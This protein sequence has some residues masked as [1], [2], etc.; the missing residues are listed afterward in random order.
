MGCFEPQRKIWSGESGQAYNLPNLIRESSDF[1]A[2]LDGLAKFD[3]KRVEQEGYSHTI[4]RLP[5]RTEASGLSD[6]TY[7]T[8]RLTELLDALREEAKYLLLFLKSV[9]KIEVVH[10][11]QAGQHKTS[12]CVEIA[13]SDYANVSFKRGLLLKDL[14]LAHKR[15]P[16]QIN[17]VISFTAEF[18]VVVTDNNSRKNQAGTSRWLVTNYVGSADPKIQ[19]AAEKQCTFPWVGAALELG[20]NSLGGRI[21]CFLPMPI[22]T[23]SG[24]PIHVNGTFGLNDERRTLKWPGV[25]RKND[26]TADWNKILVSQLLPPC[27]AMLLIEAKKYIPLDQ[28]YQAW[29]NV[30]IVKGTQFSEILY[31]FFNNLFKNPVVWRDEM[32]TLQQDGGWILVS[33]ATFVKQGTNLPSVV[34]EVLSLCKVQLVTVPPLI[35]QAI[36]Y[37]K[38]AVTEVSPK[39]ARSKLR[40]YPKSYSSCDQV[41]K[42]EILMYCLSDKCFDD[43]G[44]LKLL[45]LADGTFTTFD[46]EET[47]YL[48]SHDCP[49]SLLP[50]LDHLLVDMLDNKNVQDSLY[51]VATSQKTKLRVL[52]E[53]K[54]A[55]LL[56]Q[57]MPPKYRSSSEHMMSITRS[58]LPSSWLSAFWNWLST[59]NLKNFHNRL[60]VPCYS[61]NSHS[62]A[63]KFYLTRL[64]KEQPVIYVTS[65]ASD[66][67]SKSLLSAFYKMN[68]RVCPQSDFSFVQ[69]KQLSGYV[70]QFD[71]KSVIDLVFHSNDED[72]DFKATEADSL[73]TFLSSAASSLSKNNKT[74]LRNL[75]IFKSAS[76]SDGQLFSISLAASQSIVSIKQALGE[77]LNSIISISNLP[78]KVILLSREDYHQQQLLE[79]LQVLFPSDYQL[80]DK[81]LL[82]LIRI[83]N[84]PEDLIDSFMTEVLDMFQVFNSRESDCNLSESLKTLPFVRTLNGRKSPSELFNPHSTSITA[85]YC[86]EDVFP[87]APYNTRPII[88]V[89]KSCGLRTVVTPQEVLNI[90]QS[91]SSETPVSSHAQ[92][93]D[94]T[95]LSRSRAV[96]EYISTP[97]FYKQ[98]GEHYTLRGIKGKHSFPDA[99]KQLATR[100]CWLPVLSDPPSDY[101]EELPWKGTDCSSHFVSLSNSV[102]ILSTSTSLT[103]PHLVGSQ[104]YLVSPAVHPKVVAKLADSASIVPH[105]VAHFREILACKER[106]SVEVMNSLVH[107]VYQFLNSE[108][109]ASLSHLYSIKEWIYIKKENKF[110]APATVALKQNPE[111]RRDLEPYIYILP[112]SL[113]QYT[114]LFG[115]ESKVVRTITQQQIISIL[116][117]IRDDVQAGIH[118]ITPQE[119]WRT[120]MSI[121]NWLTNDGT[122]SVSNDVDAAN[123]LIP[124]ETE[125]QWPQLVPAPEVVYTD[126][127]FLKD[128]IQSSDEKDSYKFVHMHISAKLA[129]C[130]GGASLGDLLDISEDTFEDAGQSEP[131]TTRLKNILRDY[132]DGLTIFKEL[133]QNADDA[134]AT[135]VNVCFDARQHERN[136][137]KL[138]FSGMTEAHGPALVVHNNNTFSDDDFKNITMLAAATKQDKALKIGKFGIGFCSVYHMTDIPSF[139]SRDYLHFFDPTLSYLKKLIKNP[140][141]PG[142]KVKFTHRFISGSKQL[143]P[144]DGLF[145][146]DRAKSYNGTMFRLPFRTND[147]ELSGKCYTEATVQELISAIRVNG[148]KL[149][150]FLQHVRTITFQ[151][152]DPGQTTPVVLLKI[153]QD[154]VS[155]PI[156]LSSGTEI[157]QL[158][159]D[160]SDQ[161]RKSYNWLVSEASET[162]SQQ[163]YYTA[164]VACPLGSS[165][166]KVDAK[167]EGEIFC[168]LPLS[169][170]TGLPVHVSSNFAV[171]NNRR[172]IWTSDEA[173]SQTDR[174][175]AWN[176]TLME[177][178]IVK[179]YHNLL[180]ALK[181]LSKSKLVSDYKFYTLWPKE[182]N[183]LQ[184]NPWTLMGKKLYQVISSDPLFYSE[185]LNQWLHLFKSK[186]LTPGI[187]CQA[188]EQ[189]STL[190][191]V[192]NVLHYLNI[193]VVDLPTT[194]CIYFNL[195][196]VTITES[197]FA[198]LFFKN[199][200]ILESILSTRSEV[201]QYMLEVY[202]TEYDDETKR[203]YMLDE[204]FKKC[205]SIPCTPDGK[206]LRKCIDVIDSKATFASLFDPSEGRFPLKQL[207]DRHLSYTALGDLGMISRYIPHDM[208][209]E[210]ARTVSGLYKTDKTKALKRVQLIL[211]SC[212]KIERSDSQRVRKGKNAPV[213]YKSTN[214]VDLS[215]IPFLPVLP[216]PPDYH[217]PLWKGGDNELMC[218][219]DLVDEGSC[220]IHLAGSQ[221]AIV[222]QKAINE[223]GCGCINHETINLLKI[224]WS[225]SVKEVVAH[226]GEVHR[227]FESRPTTEELASSTDR[228]CWQ[229]YTFLNEKLE[230]EIAKKEIDH[231]TLQSLQRIACVWTG[232]QF[233]KVEVIA[234]MWNSDGP[235]LYRLPPYLYSQENLMRILKIREQFSFEDL[236]NALNKMKN[237]FRD[238][239][240]DKNCQN[241][242]GDAISLLKKIELNDSETHT[243]MLPDEN[244]VLHQSDELTYNDVHWAPKDLTHTYVHDDVPPKLAKKL[245]V[246][247]ARSK[248]IANFISPHSKFKSYKF[249][250]REKLT[251]RIQNILR[252]YPFDI[253]I[254]K[255]LLQ[256]A[257]DAKATKMYFILDKRTHGDEGL[258]SENWKKLQGPA[259]LVWNDSVFTEKD[260][261]GIQELGLGSKRFDFETIGQFGIGFN[262]VYHVTDCPSFITGGDT[263][264]VLDPHC[265][266]VNEA[267]EL[268]PG[269]RFDVSE[270]FWKSFPDMSSSYLQ[271][272]LDDCPPEIKDGSLFRFPLRTTE[273]HLKMSQI[274]QRD[275]E[276]S[277]TSGHLTATAMLEKL[278]DWA[279]RMKKAML[280]L[281]HVTEL[282]FIVI[283]ENSNRLDIKKKFCTQADESA[284]QS[285]TKLL[286]AVSAFTNKQG[287]KSE[288]VRYSLT[289]SD[290]G[291][292]GS[293][294]ERW[295][296]QQGVG[297]IDN[298]EQVWTYV[299]TVKPRHGIA[300]P[301]PSLQ[302]PN[303]SDRVAGKVE[304]F[305][306]KE[307]FVGSVF[308]FLPLPVTSDLPVHINGN[309]DLDSSRRNLY[310]STEKGRED[311]RSTWNIRL[312]Q[313]IASSYANFLDHARSYYVS[314]EPYKNWASVNSDMDRYYD[315]FPQGGLD[316]PYKALAKN[317]YKKLV[318]KN[319]RVLTVVSESDDKSCKQPL[320]VV[321]WYPPRSSDSST[322]V[323]FWSLL[324]KGDWKAIKS[325]LENIGM[326]L[327]GT[328]T[329]NFLQ[330]YLNEAFREAN[331]SFEIENTSPETVFE[332][333][334][335]FCTQ[336]SHSGQ[337]PCA[338]SDSMFRT[339]STF[340]K[341]TEY[342]LK[343]SKPV[344]YQKTDTEKTEKLAFPKEPFGHPL[345][346]TA[347][348]QLRRFQENKKAIKSKYAHLFPKCSEDFLHPD[349]VEIAYKN[350]Y[351]VDCSLFNNPYSLALANKLLC[352]HL[353]SCLRKEKRVLQFPAEL[354]RKQLTDYWKCFQSDSIFQHNLPQLL[355]DWAILPSTSGSLHS[356]ND[357]LVPIAPPVKHSSEEK[358]EEDDL[359]EQI[360]HILQKIGLPFLN[361]TITG[362]E[363]PKSCPITG[364][365][366]DIL[367]AVYQ[368]SQEKDL[369]GTLRDRVETIISYFKKIDLRYNNDSLRYVKSLPLFECIDGVFRAVVE[370]TAYVWPS[371]ASIVGY[372]DWTKCVPSILFLKDTA[373]WTKLCSSEILDIKMLSAEELY[374]RYIFNCFSILSESDRY[375]HLAHIRDYLFEKNKVYASK[376]TTFYSKERSIAVKFL[377]QLKELHCIG[378]GEDNLMPVSAYCSHEADI[379]NTFHEHFNFLPYT[380]RSTWSEWLE[381]FQE[382][383]LKHTVSKSEFTQFC[384][385][386]VDGQHEDP[387]RASSVLL[388]SLC[389]DSAKQEGW[390]VDT[391][392]LAEVRDIPFVPT[393][394][395]SDVFWIRNPQRGSITIEVDDQEVSLAKLSEAAIPECAIYLWTFKPIIN[396]PANL[397]PTIIAEHH[398][399]AK[400]LEITCE[401]TVIDVIQNIR[402]ITASKRFTDFKHFDQ[403]PDSNKQ[404][405]SPG[406]KSLMSTM[407]E[408]LTFLENNHLQLSVDHV[409]TLTDIP[410]IP[411]YSTFDKTYSW[412]VVLVE[413]CSVLR[414]GVITTDSYHPYLHSLDDQL[415]HLNYLLKKIGIESA[416]GFNHIQYVLKKAYNCSNGQEL[417]QESQNCVYAILSKLYSLLNQSSTTAVKKPSFEK[418]GETLCPLYLPNKD[419]K[420]ALSTTLLYVDD[421]NFKG[422]LFPTLEGTEYSMIKIRIPEKGIMVYDKDFCE[423]LPVKVRPIGLST[424]CTQTIL[425][426]C[427]TISHTSAGKHLMETFE[428]NKTLSEAISA[429][430]QYLTKLSQNFEP[431]TSEFLSGIEIRTVKHLRMAIRFKKT[432]EMLGELDTKFFLQTPSDDTLQ[433]C[434]YLDSKMSTKP[435]YLFTKMIS[436]LATRL[437]QVLRT[438]IDQPQLINADTYRTL[439]KVI[440]HLL[441]AQ[442][443]HEVQEIMEDH[444]IPLTGEGM[445]SVTFKL[446][447]EVPEY[448]H[449]RLDQTI[450]NV[451]HP[452]EIVGFEEM[453]NHIVYA[454]I[455]HPILPGVESFDDI[456]RIH[457]KYKI[458]T[459]P[460]DEDGTEANVLQLYKFLKGLEKEMPSAEGETALVLFEGETE[461]AQLQQELRKENIQE[462]C[463]D[464]KRQLNEIWELP[465]QDRKKAIRRLCLKWHPDKNLD[466]QELAEEVFKFLNSEI[467]KRNASED[468]Q[469]EDLK[470]TARQQR[471]FYEREWYSFRSRSGFTGSRFSSGMPTFDEENLRPKRNM[472]EGRRW[473]K[474]AEANF[475][476]L[477][478]LYSGS[479]QDS[480]V[481]GDVCFMAHQVAEKALKGGKYFV[482]GLDANSLRTHNLSTHAYGLQAERP[483]ETHGLFAHALPLEN[484][485][486]N[487]RYPNQWP[488]GVVPA[489]QYTYEQAEAAKKHAQAILDIVKGLVD[490]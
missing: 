285:H 251:R 102:A 27:Y 360:Y 132:K 224:R 226:L 123:I 444:N 33:N 490:I 345:L 302:K 151:R 208:L 25:E 389:S 137:K 432:D 443:S 10:I 172:G 80:L 181:E 189:S 111:F 236:K 56:I 324:D 357:S 346:I 174:E 160:K 54:V 307:K 416:I 214:R 147:S 81:Y 17:N 183:L 34:R 7:T 247:P 404:P 323:Y 48:C 418:I 227:V 442:S 329:S 300:A 290:I 309:F 185:S 276:G 287:N 6:N 188:S 250:Q 39:L 322:Q 336:A 354:T 139:I 305:S 96:L 349:M 332:Y 30:D 37:A 281:N 117:M 19:A 468:V 396:L 369:S 327:T 398:L 378:S 13:P 82:P 413:P 306:G 353:P 22:E 451:F 41:S 392:F 75:K 308:C 469:W 26:L 362:S 90:I 3:S 471:H 254:L 145:G 291:Q 220:N 36:K 157:R 169:Q 377:K 88:K 326:K 146:F 452:G 473:L 118:R 11:S 286:R 252:R 127:E 249:G 177:G 149:L 311:D 450:E 438:R 87:Q 83:G 483:I 430:V 91:I 170:K 342:L 243:L 196:K 433:V 47:L 407:V 64:N 325:I 9:C 465:E 288:V 193:P 484:Y 99:M 178:V 467:S 272:G 391:T 266:Y 435:S 366:T 316:K 455:M 57:I 271:S 29:P 46:S 337:F 462:I 179:A 245:G 280:F 192:L 314:S 199:L 237:D 478:F 232:R 106:L 168:F 191:C 340:I 382:L 84:F 235:Y 282:Q 401:A 203:S 161:S 97:D 328:D 130:L 209:V 242:L 427:I 269:R 479:Q 112:E 165:S 71:P 296:I 76:N 310:T 347:D 120:I 198:E 60:I 69:H 124:V 264:C 89:L 461:P 121:F 219:K 184:R 221:V 142:K 122:E 424:V 114:L 293:T 74:V 200:S 153:T 295:L 292:K 32:E 67:C 376:T 338:I 441:N 144:Y 31:S 14:T 289:I 234:R 77:P 141:Q 187:L 154:T 107:E 204:Y 21:F 218:G 105:V 222:N 253:T 459:N 143:D 422:T 225:P 258:L 166:Y 58:Q 156:S 456:P 364:T 485:Y 384:W 428:M 202:A 301:I 23:S 186:F 255:E 246:K 262:V 171:I 163:E 283:E 299:S 279:P 223:G 140:A 381:F 486:L 85:L 395:P 330:T 125:S 420:L 133:L 408:N 44:G 446:G 110:I 103:L 386:I 35:W 240:V 197:T 148:I 421:D 72:T 136:P 319:S 437:L 268:Y 489:D 355:K 477:L 472:T 42:L 180:L 431:I 65:Y 195:K 361:T 211:S 372:S 53:K 480:D 215:S 116:K 101:C 205:A 294:E 155:L 20:D 436:L 380:F 15:H 210:R 176:I 213:E 233:I 390:H 270:S 440:S 312:F 173:T 231:L 476:S 98:A 55:D 359:L 152:I 466:N 414:C 158:S 43:L 273:D 68:M 375:H 59:R 207:S 397:Q 86:G 244:Y 388:E 410:C 239:P 371:D 474:Q 18:S 228:M 261:D 343:S 344:G 159:C 95:K 335:K 318:Q 134:E 379:F 108:E 365:V 313:A 24:L 93:V 454:M 50:N 368:L 119:A 275:E 190:E 373:S 297:D 230:P 212:G 303:L 206:I 201:I 259:L 164:S 481:C 400:R 447:R 92:L 2:S 387:I 411:V 406:T 439:Q 78:E 104:M 464:L 238:L 475:S 423:S 448:W 175:V 62:A 298:E 434:L 66:S 138:F 8:Q 333:Y 38:V 217:L 278:K 274:I 52:S 487:P 315:I 341:F 385:E 257:D 162:N 417:E 182:D 321:K 405:D 367:K 402:N 126:S 334:C 460:E 403:Y 167:F 445:D 260:L 394:C 5:L 350:K 393:Q 351:F 348:S 267:N 277:P 304:Q 45:P 94:S 383:G 370:R 263:L 331:S 70:H 317:V 449:H 73:R 131:L 339:V 229:I 352:T 28:F 12:F 128:Y 241:F 356:S 358:S 216:R 399:L 40:S 284:L 409:K 482:C 16:Y 453:E 320:K 265:K 374:Y 426:N 194:Y 256:N 129:E 100:R 135:E 458:M 51:R 63:K 463:S 248:V 419:A 49:R 115:T 109:I 470:R 412:Q 150:L 79:T 1:A 425:S 488:P 415:S 457:M 113:T 4:F 429:C 363:I 61:S